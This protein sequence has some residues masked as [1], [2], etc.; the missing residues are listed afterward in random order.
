MLDFGLETRIIVINK[1]G[2]TKKKELI[3]MTFDYSKLRGRIREVYGK[4][5][6]LVPKISMSEAT[7][8]RKLNGKSYFDSQE[9]LELSD[10]LEI[11]D[12]ERDIY[13]FKVEVQK[14]E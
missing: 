14:S 5:E 3:Y 9:I 12:E 13:F 10:A 4:Y 1:L 2:N 7:L 6:N 8:S 11:P